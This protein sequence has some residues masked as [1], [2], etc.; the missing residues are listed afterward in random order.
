M[1]ETPCRPLLSGGAVWR[2]AEPHHVVKGPAAGRT[3]PPRGSAALPRGS[4]EVLMA[5]DY[6]WK[7]GSQPP[8]E[9]RFESN[10]DAGAGMPNV[11]GYGEHIIPQGQVW[12]VPA[13]ASEKY[14]P[15]ESEMNKQHSTQSPVVAAHG[16]RRYS[17]AN[18]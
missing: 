8:D 14:L 12:L 1:G 5:S 13:S 11:N 3:E 16:S 2:A 17:Y 7:F 4:G 6:P 18:R 9:R 15:S 10:W